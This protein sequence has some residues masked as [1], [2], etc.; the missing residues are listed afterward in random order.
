MP[1]REASGRDAITE[2]LERAR[3]TH[4]RAL[5][6]DGAGGQWPVAV[7]RPDPRTVRLEAAAPLPALVGEPWLEL[8]LPG[9][10][11]LLP[12]ALRR[13]AGDAV[14]A[15]LPA[16]ARAASPAAVGADAGWTLRTGRD[17]WPVVRADL[18][19]L[20]VVGDPPPGP[21]IDATL[22]AGATTLPLT[23][24]VAARLRGRTVLRPAGAP[25]AY[26]DLIARRT[27]SR[28]RRSAAN[29]AAVWDVF[30]DSGLLGTFADPTAAARRRERYAAATARLEAVPQLGFK[31]DWLDEQQ[32]P[33][34]SVS[35]L[36]LHERAWFGLHL[37]K[38][39]GDA[40]DGT[41]GKRVL[42]EIFVQWHERLAADPSAR[43]LVNLLRDQPGFPQVAVRDD[44]RHLQ[45]SG[46]TCEVRSR[47]IEVAIGAPDPAAEAA[48][49]RP[50][51]GELTTI[52]DAIAAI[53]PHGYREAFDLV[54][55]RLDGAGSAAAW[56]A[57]GLDR[58][59]ELFVLPAAD[60]GLDGV[61]VA[62]RLTPGLHLYDLLDLTRVYVFGGDGERVLTALLERVA[63]W[64]R[65]AGRERFVLLVDDDL[66]IDE[67]RLA[68][69]GRDLGEVDQVVLDLR[70]EPVNVEGLRRRLAV[71]DRT[72]VAAA[73]RPDGPGPR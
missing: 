6:T 39:Q 57:A 8:V 68:T 47:V 58:G 66:A 72:P 42:D 67:R 19:S 54:A 7:E 26:H 32:Q 4:A 3:E 53:R 9:S 49:R 34:A 46:G 27:W 28:T 14:E 37:A 45:A 63:R 33:F 23:L 70:L 59:R 38:P 20:V 5:L 36:K 52:A 18:A 30:A 35:C 11:W 1:I 55:E 40:A 73:A 29:G 51:A 10:S 25:Y 12:L 22:T 44:L 17:A 15:A 65:D 41:P 31:L 48:V 50:T 62:E 71:G 69:L 56:A 61:A 24:E 13:V 60:A 64:Y 16:V 43:W 21:R 2:L